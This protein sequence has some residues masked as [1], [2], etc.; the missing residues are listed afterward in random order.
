LS[1]HELLDIIDVLSLSPEKEIWIAISQRK[2]HTK[3]EREEN[4]SQGSTSRPE[5]VVELSLIPKLK[6]AERYNDMH[7]RPCMKH[8]IPPMDWKWRCESGHEPLDVK[9]STIPIISVGRP[10]AT[11]ILFIQ[12]HNLIYSPKKIVN[13]Y[14]QKI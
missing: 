2:T 13:V 12:R 9:S 5:E 3:K 14:Y 10:M 11:I 6:V 7:N 8:D 4:D 1:Y